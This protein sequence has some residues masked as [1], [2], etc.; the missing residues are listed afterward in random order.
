LK[1]L[2]LSLTSRESEEDREKSRGVNILHHM[3]KFNKSIITT[4]I[5][6]ALHWDNPTQL[7]LANDVDEFNTIDQFCGFR[8]GNEN[9]AIPIVNIQEVVSAQHISP[10][11]KAAK[12]VKGLIN[13]RGQIVTSICLRDVFHYKQV[14]NNEHMNIIVR[15]SSGFAALMIDEILDVV[16]FD[17]SQYSQV[18]DNVSTDLRKYFDCVYKQPSGLTTIVNVNAIL[19]DMF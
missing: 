7:A 12:E 9:Y 10:V 3:I 15:S 6:Q 19:D 1:F 4:S 11:A 16:N 13:L 18:P 8:I 14:A 17:P 5:N 2:Y